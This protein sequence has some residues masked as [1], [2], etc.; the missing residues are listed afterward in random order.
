MKIIMVDKTEPLTK[1]L[2]YILNIFQIKEKCDLTFSKLTIKNGSL[3]G[4]K[5]KLY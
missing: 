5:K 4:L 1:V 3:E 2:P